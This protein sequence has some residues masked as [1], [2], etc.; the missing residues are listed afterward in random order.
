VLDLL[1]I[2]MPK[3]KTVAEPTGIIPGRTYNQYKYQLIRKG[4]M[5]V[6]CVVVVPEKV[7]PAGKVVLYLNEAGKDAVLND[8]ATL[9]N[10]VNQGD[11]LVVAELRGYG[12]TAD[13]SSLNDVKYRNRE[14][15]NAMISLHIGKSIVG[16]RV[17]DIMS[18]VDFVSTDSRLAGHEIRLLANGSYGPVAIH[19]AFLDNRIALTEISRSMRS[20]FEFLQ[21][22]MQQDAF[23]NVI[24]GVLK[25]YDLKDLAGKAGK[26]RIVFVD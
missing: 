1:G 20:Y 24:P 21:N 12:E 5:P 8:E 16:Q 19:A 7:A 15:R 17:I 10:Y 11:I 6:P 13:P 4:E 14:Y 25:Q 26:G 3:E 23:T 18:L 9:L 22:P 2:S